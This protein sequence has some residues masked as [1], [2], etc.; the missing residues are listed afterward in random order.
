MNQACNTA[1]PSSVTTSTIREMK[2]IAATPRA[3]VRMSGEN[4]SSRS[5]GRPEGPQLTSASNTIRPCS[6]DTSHSAPRLSGSWPAR[7]TASIVEG[8]TRRWRWTMNLITQARKPLEAG[9]PVA[10]SS[11]NSGPLFTLVIVDGGDAGTGEVGGV[12]TDSG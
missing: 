2:A 4:E 9:A 10:V 1:A 7:R 11:Q 8:S 6:L 3:P 5:E 12:T